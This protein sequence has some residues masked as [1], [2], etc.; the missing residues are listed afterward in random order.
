MHLEIDASLASDFETK[1]VSVNLS[2]K[3]ENYC[4]TA[5]NSTKSFEFRKFLTP[6]K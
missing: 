2:K 3:L 6:V 4:K 1:A 5:T